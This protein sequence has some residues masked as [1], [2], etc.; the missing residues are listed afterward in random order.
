MSAAPPKPRFLSV[1]HISW[2]VPDLD[3]AVAFYRDVIGAE[4]L[5]RMG[6][7]V[8]ALVEPAAKVEI[9]TLAVVSAT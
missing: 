3:A 6:P 7:M 4:E 1:D 8:A 9:E 5:F 2:T